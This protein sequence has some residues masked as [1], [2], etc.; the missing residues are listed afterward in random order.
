MLGVKGKDAGGQA[1]SL[2]QSPTDVPCRYQADDAR[3]LRRMVN[4]TEERIREMEHQLAN[5]R[6]AQVST[7]QDL[8]PL[9]TPLSYALRLLKTQSAP[10]AC[11]SRTEHPSAPRS[12]TSRRLSTAASFAHTTSWT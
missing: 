10:T 12:R 8:F 1:E 9:L 11:W 7:Y 2:G 3:H 5:A 4:L 6:S